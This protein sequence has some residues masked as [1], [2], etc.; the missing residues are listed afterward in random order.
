MDSVL[1]WAADSTGKI[2]PPVIHSLSF[3]PFTTSVYWDKNY[4]Y[5]FKLPVRNTS[6]DLLNAVLCM[7]KFT[8]ADMYLETEPGEWEHRK[9]GMW[10][11]FSERSYPPNRFCHPILLRGGQEK[12]F[13]LQVSDYFQEGLRS[14]HFRL[15]TL[16]QEK[17]QR[18]DEASEQ[19][20]HQLFKGLFFGILTFFG[21]YSLIQYRL[22]QDKAFLFY[23]CY[24][25]SLIFFYLR[26]LDLQHPLPFWGDLK[27]I[28]P[29]LEAPLGYL[30]YIFY[31]AFL[32]NFLDFRHRLPLHDQFLRWGAYFFIGLMALDL[33]VIQP[34]WGWRISLEI[35]SLTKLPFFLLSLWVVISAAIK[36][37]NRMASYILIGTSLLLLPAIFTVYADLTPGIYKEI[38]SN[39]ARSFKP[40]GHTTTFYMYDMRMGLLLEM[41]CFLM[42]LTWKIE[43]ENERIRAIATPNPIS[44]GQSSPTELALQEEKTLLAMVRMVISENL[45]DEDFNVEKLSRKMAMS[46]TKLFRNL[47]AEGVNA[48]ELIQSM[49]LQKAKALLESTPM[50]LPQIADEVG[51]KSAGQLSRAFKRVFGASPRK[52]NGDS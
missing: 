14:P 16:A 25:I 1:L 7:D 19:N 49:R 15:M 6:N 41:L 45:A 46:R 31:L 4:E 8:H 24:I 21:L 9:A 39:T 2:G 3:Q 30:C 40:E 47:Q 26:S 38:F 43:K 36:F 42:A 37:K 35:Q 22:Y 51:Y 27:A 11:N 17:E 10:T 33:L 44:S 28:H 20:G 48:S 52:Q 29:N 32:R 12:M 18:L 34:F 13:Y 50:T 5:W 23:S